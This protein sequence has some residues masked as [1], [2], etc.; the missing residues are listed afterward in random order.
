M[1]EDEACQQFSIP[2]PLVRERYKIRFA[3]RHAV[4]S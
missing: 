1:I 3:I 4:L 2:K